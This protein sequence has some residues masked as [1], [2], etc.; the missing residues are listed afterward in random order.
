MERSLSTNN[1]TLGDLLAFDLETTGVDPNTDLPVSYSLIEYSGGEVTKT[2]AGLINPMRPI[3]EG[4]TAIHGITDAQVQQTGREL[5]LAIEDISDM[6][7]DASIRGIPVVGMNV[8]YDLKMIEACSIRLFGTPL[9]DLGWR[10]GPVVDIL[11][12]DRHF[13]KYRKGKRKLADLCKTYGVD[14][15]TSFHD[16]SSDASAS[17]SVLLKQAERYSEITETDPTTLHDKQILWYRQWATDF[18][19]YIVS[20]GG[21]PL[22]QS[23][24]SW[25]LSPSTTESTPSI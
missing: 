15:S 2:K 9:A 14:T 20:M 18:S 3:P 21:E 12:L 5:D 23:E 8:S 7:V 19:K 16:A 10:G 22:P 6:L 4:A 24:L 13:D 1:W 17:V 11:V 25:P